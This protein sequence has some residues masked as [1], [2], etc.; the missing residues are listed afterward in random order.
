MLQ[1][2]CQ[3]T[4]DKL[5]DVLP[6]ESFQNA[7][8][9]YRCVHNAVLWWCDNKKWFD[10]KCL[11]FSALCSRH[12]IWN[13]LIWWMKEKHLFLC[14]LCSIVNK[15]LS[16]PSSSRWIRSSA[17]NERN[18]CTS[19]TDN[20]T[21]L[22]CLLKERCAHSKQL[23]SIL[24]WLCWFKSSASVVSRKVQWRS[25]DD[26]LRPISDQQSLHVTFW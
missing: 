19:S 1:T 13:E 23:R 25:N 8:T 12:Q 26:F 4:F 6:A 11:A 17:I 24:R 7:N 10:L 9:M 16:T 20:Q 18:I 21:A 15:I 5:L 2:W 22:F 3:L 14:S